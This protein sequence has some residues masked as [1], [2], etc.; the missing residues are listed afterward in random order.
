VSYAEKTA[1]RE[2]GQLVKLGAADGG[3]LEVHVVSYAVPALEAKFRRTIDAPAATPAI[4]AN[5]D[6]LDPA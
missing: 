2:F 5:S 1:P 4:G 6:E 3:P